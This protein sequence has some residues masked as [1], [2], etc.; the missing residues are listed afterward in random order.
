MKKLFIL[1]T[2]IVLQ[3]CI[4]ITGQDKFP[5]TQ[6]TTIT[7]RNG[8][9]TWSPEGKFLIYSCIVQNDSL[10]KTGLW[11]I[12][13]DGKEEQQIYNEIAEHP[14]WSPDGKYIV[15]DADSGRSMK[16][17]ASNGGPVIKIIPDSMKIF[18]G[19]MPCWSPDSKQIAFVEGGTLTLYVVDIISGRLTKIF[20]QE[21]ILPIPG[22]WS[23]EGD[24]IYVGLM[25]LKTRLSTMW[26]IAFDG[27]TK[28]QITGH[29]Q[30]F[31][32]YMDLSPD[33]TLLV[34]GA[35]EQKE[36]KINTGIWIMPASG[37][38]SVQLVSHQSYNDAPQWSPD[39]KKIIY[40]SSRSKGF[41]LMELDIE[42]IK[43]ELR[44]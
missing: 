24:Y 42:L 18:K 12:S 14:R 21:E 8:F 20:H 11:K 38:K 34:Y 29:H 30:G 41:L 37:G 15:F 27:K 22:C 6:I 35:I 28:M 40:T 25:E 23:K 36:S 10:S 26:K 3:F 44:D 32:R 9:P 16:M 4:S 33:G 17:I 19:A 5:S 1:I 13:V 43:I 7:E 2:V 39:G 31:Y